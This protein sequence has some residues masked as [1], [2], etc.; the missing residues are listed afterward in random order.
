MEKRELIL[1][2]ARGP[3][4]EIVRGSIGTFRAVAHRWAIRKRNYEVIKLG[5]V[6]A[7]IVTSATVA[8]EAAPKNQAIP[9]PKLVS[10]FEPPPKKRGRGRPRK[11]PAK[12]V[13]AA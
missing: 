3:N 11:H 8:T 7:P 9:V 6:E 2:A 10:A 4:G 1:W 13:E 5:T 12:N